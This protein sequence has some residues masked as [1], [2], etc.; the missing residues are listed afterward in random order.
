MRSPP[1]LELRSLVNCSDSSI[2]TS[3][4]KEEVAS[5]VS[6]VNYIKDINMV[7]ASSKTLHIEGALIKA[8][9]D[10]CQIEAK[11]YYGRKHNEKEV[12]NNPG[13]SHSRILKK[14]SF[15]S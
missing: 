2:K 6:L 9:R 11:K 10:V 15:C 13:H 4:D 1:D 5:M 12:D 3:S 7:Y 14:K 8:C